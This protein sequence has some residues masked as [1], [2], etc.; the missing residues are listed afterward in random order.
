M[1]VQGMVVVSRLVFRPFVNV[2][3]YASTDLDEIYLDGI[4]LDEIYPLERNSNYSVQV[5]KGKLDC[6]LN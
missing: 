1:F 6:R 3:T 5:K 2:N 4:D